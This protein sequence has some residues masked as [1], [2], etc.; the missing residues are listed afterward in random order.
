MKSKLFLALSA[1]V[2]LLTSTGPLLASSVVPE[3]STFVLMGGGIGA[4]LVVRHF[5]NRK[6]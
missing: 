6:K 3:P 1:G 4:L 5:V 2:L